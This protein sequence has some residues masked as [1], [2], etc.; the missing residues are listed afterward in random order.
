MEFSRRDGDIYITNSEMF[1]PLGAQRFI[2]HVDLYSSWSKKSYLQ[3]SHLQS[4][5]LTKN[6]HLEHSHSTKKKPSLNAQFSASDNNIPLQ[7]PTFSIKKQFSQ[8]KN[9]KQWLSQLSTD[10]FQKTITVN[11]SIHQ[12]A[13]SNTKRHQHSPPTNTNI[14]Q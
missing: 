9:N 12:Y 14:L 10:I 13:A 3:V 5:D 4:W 7:T 6:Q 11:T 8:L 2:I 1:F